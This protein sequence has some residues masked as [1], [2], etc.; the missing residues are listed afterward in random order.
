MSEV[1]KLIMS[2]IHTVGSLMQD[3][4]QPVVRNRGRLKIPHSD[5]FNVSPDTLEFATQTNRFAA[6]DDRW[7]WIDEF[8]VPGRPVAW[9][10]QHAEAVFIRRQK[11]KLSLGA[12]AREFDVSTPTIKAAIRCFEE[13]HPGIKDQVKVQ[14]GGKRPEKFDLSA[15]GPDSRKLLEQGDTKLDL[16]KRF[17][18]ST[19]VID[20]AIAWAYQ[21]EGLQ[22]PTSAERT[23]ARIEQVRR[24]D[25]EGKTLIEICNIMDVSDV[26]AR[27]YLRQSERSCRIEGAVEDAKD[28]DFA[29]A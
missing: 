9:V 14:C 22:V 2:D 25:N 17:G 29:C 23:A 10:D 21:Q 26:T 16:A 5:D 3:D 20:R 18:C 4:T 12:L 27:K 13:A 1:Q 19:P 24:L 11:S 28:D 6:L 7:F 8:Q 15:I